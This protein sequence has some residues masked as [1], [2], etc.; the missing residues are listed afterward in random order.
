MD[1]KGASC[2]FFRNEEKEIAL[3]EIAV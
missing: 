2:F 1:K 3:I